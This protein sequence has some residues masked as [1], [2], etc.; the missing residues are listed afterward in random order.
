MNNL[1][2]P[3]EIVDKPTDPYR[4]TCILEELRKV[5]NKNPERTLGE[6]IA[7]ILERE[8]KPVYLTYIT[9]DEF[10]AAIQNYG[11]N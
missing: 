10:L 4:I 11:D 9:D 8:Y 6:I 1:I 3:I 7:A 5:W 2:T